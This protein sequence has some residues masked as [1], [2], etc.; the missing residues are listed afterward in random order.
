MNNLHM[1]SWALGILTAAALGTVAVASDDTQAIPTI[2]HDRVA[3]I[4][5]AAGY[6]LTEFEAEDGQ[7]EAEGQR[8]GEDW[9]VVID[10]QTGEIL[11][12]ERDD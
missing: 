2:Q 8:A 12:A 11:S 7:I 9:E 1:T 4:M 10:A 6:T 5:E 3:A